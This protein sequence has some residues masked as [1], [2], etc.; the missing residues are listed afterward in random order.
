MFWKVLKQFFGDVL[1]VCGDKINIAA[2]WAKYFR[3]VDGRYFG[4]KTYW[5]H[6]RGVGGPSS[7]EI[8]WLPTQG[9]LEHFP[10]R[11][12]LIWIQPGSVGTHTW[13]GGSAVS[14]R[15]VL[16]NSGLDSGSQQQLLPPTLNA[17][18]NCSLSL[19]TG[20]VWS[21]SPGHPV[22]VQMGVC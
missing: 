7:W 10:L 4:A 9:T 22:L 19:G 12:S 14:A 11:L 5:W 18:L 15:A 21:P 20:W 1:S 8:P 17:L 16:G 6:L 2:A 3:C 13:T